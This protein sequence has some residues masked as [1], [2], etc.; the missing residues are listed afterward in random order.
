MIDKVLQID[1]ALHYLIYH[2]FISSLIILG[3]T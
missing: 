1:M 3:F 2:Y